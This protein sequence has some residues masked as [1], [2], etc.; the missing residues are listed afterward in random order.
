M[1]GVD[2]HLSQATQ[3]ETSH[4]LGALVASTPLISDAWTQCAVANTAAP[5]G[6]V[7]DRIGDI[8]YV[9]FSG[10]QILSGDSFSEVPIVTGNDL[11][12]VVAEHEGTPATV[13]ARFLRRFLSIYDCPDF[14][15]KITATMSS[16]KV[17]VFAGH[18]LGGAIASLAALSI[19]SSTVA[20][21]H[22]LFCVTFGSPLIGNKALSAA[23]ID[24]GWAHRF[25]H[26]AAAHDLV[27]RL[28]LAPLP[29]IW[30]QINHLFHF[31]QSC[32]QSPPFST[33][34][35]VSL[36]LTEPE[37][38]ELN[39]FIL[40]HVSVG[41]DQWGPYWPFGNFLFC[42]TDGAICVDDPTAVI[43]LLRLLMG[44]AE[45]S[46]QD[47]ITYGDR[48][49]RIS[50]Q[51]LLRRRSDGREGN[52]SSEVGISLALEALGV[53]QDLSKIG[54]TQ[55]CLMMAAKR[56]LHPNLNS[57]S[58]AIRLAKVTPC[59]AQIEWYKAYCDNQGLSYYDSFKLRL[60]PKRDSAVNMARFK[61]G[62]FWDRVIEMLQSNQLPSD[63][64]RRAKFVNASHLYM[65]MVEPLEI[66]EYYRTGK[67]RT[68]GHY[69]VG[70]REKR[71]QVFDKWWQQRTVAAGILSQRK[72]R[73]LAGWTQDSCFWVRVE[74]ANDWMESI[75]NEKEALR[76][77]EL[78]EKMEM[79][80]EYAKNLVERK[81]VSRDVLAEKSSYSVWVKEWDELKRELP[82]RVPFRG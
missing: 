58:L 47:H 21:T 57:A 14:H 68:H 25:C 56:G 29:P 74:E 59:R 9:A 23:I 33:K 15:G 69:L 80:G 81:E 64:P 72:R 22:S 4:M 31:W 79:F 39:R 60:A 82:L 26:V 19:L 16:K 7:V 53:T 30:T 38:V 77:A 6:F 24:Q 28:F 3:F 62:N 50:E 12:S 34:P 41:E 55:K 75:R 71:F 46:I 73:T 78:W 51:F 11:F 18:S 1:A 32:M 8:A 20:T 35:V 37:I 63:F 48:A 5:G 44:S 49:A 42:S 76:Q 36:S 45:S 27:P 67:H 54:P 61:L 2:A 43:Q 40:A 52:V 70:G 13:Y 65:L 66:A 10:V 17:M